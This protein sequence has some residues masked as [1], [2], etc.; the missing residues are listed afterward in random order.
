MLWDAIRRNNLHN[1]RVILSAKFPVDTPLNPLGMT[2]LHFAASS[3]N[4]QGSNL[5]LI[6]E[7][8]K[9]NA[10]INA[11]DTVSTSKNSTLR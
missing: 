8:M 2:A 6:Q 7:I 5:E 11:R 3:S 4:E 10:N 9:F 1:V